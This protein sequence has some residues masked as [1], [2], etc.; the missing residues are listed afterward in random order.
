MYW[1]S[2]QGHQFLDEEAVH[3][4]YAVCSKDVQQEFLTS[5]TSFYLYATSRVLHSPAFYHYHVVADGSV[6]QQDL[7]FLR[8]SSH[9]K[10]SIHPPY[11]HSVK[12][13]KLCS[14]ERIYL[15]EHEDFR[16]MDKVNH[17]WREP[18]GSPMYAI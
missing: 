9:F 1:L 10:T 16:N 17:P 12:L 5:L 15:H 18:F 3:L 11:R 7:A 2:E 13:F 8:P 4:V 6:V 14:T